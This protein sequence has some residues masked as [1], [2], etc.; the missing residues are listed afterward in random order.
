MKLPVTVIFLTRLLGEHDV[1]RW[2][3]LSAFA[4]KLH[5]H[6]REVQK[7]LFLHLQTLA[8]QREDFGFV[9]SRH[10]RRQGVGRLP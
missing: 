5:V 4:E 10:G 8:E 9:V 3:G 2:L 1:F 6:V 7:R